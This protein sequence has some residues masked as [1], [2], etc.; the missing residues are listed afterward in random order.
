MSPHNRDTILLW[1][2]DLSEVESSVCVFLSAN[3]G[4][5]ITFVE[6]L[7]MISFVV[8]KQ[9][10]LGQNLDGLLQ[11]RLHHSASPIIFLKYLVGLHTSS[12][13]LTLSPGVSVTLFL[14]PTA[15][16]DAFVVHVQCDLGH[17]LGTWLQLVLHQSVIPGCP[18]KADVAWHESLVSS[19]T[20]SSS[21]S[22]PPPP[23]P[24]LGLLLSGATVVDVVVVLL[25]IRSVS[26]KSSSAQSPPPSTVLQSMILSPSPSSLLWR[27]PPPRR[28]KEACN[29]AKQH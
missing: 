7:K 17:I 23:I 28:G 2:E 24:S 16:D 11:L 8:Q 3:Y 13:L 9:N 12:V 18:A 25:L 5:C 4:V 22:P 1:K 15:D 26:G 19:A 6:V 27:K 29:E 14:T 21:S 10:R 20:M